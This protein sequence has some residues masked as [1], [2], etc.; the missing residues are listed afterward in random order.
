MREMEVL[1]DQLLDLLNTDADLEPRDIMVLTPDIESY[2]PYI[3][4]VFGAPE[5]S[6]LRMP[7]SIADR[8]P[9]ACNPVVVAF[10]FL[11]TLNQSRLPVSEIL[12]LLEVP[13]VRSR[14]DLTNEDMH[15]IRQWISETRI[16][17]GAD[18]AAKSRL[19]LPP[20]E[21]NTWQAGLDRL[22][23]GYALSTED[24]LLFKGILPAGGAEGSDAEVLG[25]L[26][27]F[28]ATL[29]QW[30]TRLSP[31]RDLSEWP[32]HLMQLIDDFLKPVAPDDRDILLL[33]RLIADM[34]EHV[35]GSE[36]K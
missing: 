18:A 26:E 4:A 33:H 1:Y 8:G 17:W 6:A 32:S 19:A 14:F 29:A 5:D 12:N 13:A 16:C 3:Q 7:F 27:R 23:M 28:I 20:T 10:F 25:H 34:A 24:D 35:D 11:L 30:Q 21:A 22:L 2:A 9:M 36:G 31:S 15:L